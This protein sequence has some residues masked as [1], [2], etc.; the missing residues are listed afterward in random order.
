MSSSSKKS[1]FLG[2]P[3]GTANARLRKMILFRLIKKCGEDTCF[4][5][6]K[7]IGNLD[8][9][10][11]EHKLPWENRSVDLF[12]DLDNIAFSHLKCNT[13]IARRGPTREEH[14]RTKLSDNEVKRLLEI[15]GEGVK[16]QALSK[17]FGISERHVR[18][19]KQVR[20]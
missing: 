2:M 4:R 15:S 5:C 12:W 18:H 17:M 3:H 16:T 19:I 11:I 13:P 10:S 9:L 7:A 8:D 14:A 1:A 6:G 20:K